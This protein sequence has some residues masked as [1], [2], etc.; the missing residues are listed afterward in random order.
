ISDRALELQRELR[1]AEIESE[2]ERA[3]HRKRHTTYLLEMLLDRSRIDPTALNEAEDIRRES[4]REEGAPDEWRLATLM[5]LGVT[6]QENGDP[7]PGAIADLIPQ[8]PSD[9]G[10]DGNPNIRC[11]AWGARLCHILGMGD[12]RLKFVNAI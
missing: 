9:E 8:L 6:L 7:L 10:S 4:A 11:M 12:S 3:E 2:G 1:D 5:K